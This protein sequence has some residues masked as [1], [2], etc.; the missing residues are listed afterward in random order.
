M[1]EWVSG[2][3]LAAVIFVVVAVILVVIQEDI[4]SDDSLILQLLQGKKSDQAT[5]EE[6]EITSTTDK[7]GKATATA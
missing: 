7:K 2:T 5:L 4:K 6:V 1:V 3:W